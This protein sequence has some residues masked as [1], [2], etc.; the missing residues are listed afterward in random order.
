MLLTEYDEKET[1]RRLAR[2]ER[3]EGRAEER[4]NLLKRMLD[5]GD[6]TLDIAAKNAGMAPEALSEQ[7]R[8]YK[9]SHPD[10]VVSDQKINYE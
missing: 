6:I 7:I 1:M 8:K 5:S 9:E 3:A 4:I 10:S 2:D